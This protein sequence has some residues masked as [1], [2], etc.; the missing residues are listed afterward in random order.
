MVPG[1]CFRILF[2]YT[3][4]DKDT[5][6]EIFLAPKVEEWDPFHIILHPTSARVLVGP[7]DQHT[8]SLSD[9]SNSSLEKNEYTT[10]V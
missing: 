2:W 4:H 3:I 5:I 9:T 6:E 1:Y 10:E 8:F 7:T